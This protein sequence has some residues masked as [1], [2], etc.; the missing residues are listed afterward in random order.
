MDRVESWMQ[1]QASATGGSSPPALVTCIPGGGGGHGGVVRAAS[2]ND[3]AGVAAAT[4]NGCR[5]NLPV[6]GTQPLQPP[7]P[8]TPLNRNC[9]AG[10]SSYS[11]S[12]EFG[13]GAHTMQ[14]AAT[15][16]TWAGELGRG[17]G[18]G[19]G[20]AV[21]GGNSD[22][23]PEHVLQFHDG[24]ACAV[25]GVGGTQPRLLP[26]GVLDLAPPLWPLQLPLSLEPLSSVPRTQAA[27]PATV[28]GLSGG[29]AGRQGDMAVSGSGWGCLQER[30]RNG[31]HGVSS[32]PCRTKGR[33]LADG[34]A[35]PPNADCDAADTTGGEAFIPNPFIELEVGA[36]MGGN[37]EPEALLTPV[38]IPPSPPT[39]LLQ[40]QQQ[41]KQRRNVSRQVARGAGNDC[42][43]GGNHKRA[44]GSAALQALLSAGVPPQLL[45][46]LLAHTAGSGSSYEESC[47]RDARSGVVAD[48]PPPSTP[49]HAPAPQSHRNVQVTADLDDSRTA[50]P[51]SLDV[52]A[53]EGRWHQPHQ[54]LLPL[55]ARQTQLQKA[56]LPTSSPHPAAHRPP[57]NNPHCPYHVSNHLQLQQLQVRQQLLPY[58][59]Q[60]PPPGHA[61]AGV[62]ASPLN[63]P[64]AP[65][66]ASAAAAA[67]A[68]DPAALDPPPRTWKDAAVASILRH[69]ARPPQ[70]P[71]A[72]HRPLQPAPT[73][74]QT[75]KSHAA[76]VNAAASNSMIS[77]G[78]CGAFLSPGSVGGRAE[79]EGYP[80]TTS[81]VRQEHSLISASTCRDSTLPPRPGPAVAE[82]CLE[83]R[84]VRPPEERPLI[85]P[86]FRQTQP[87][88]TDHG[89][90][91][92]LTV[93]TQPEPAD[94]SAA[95]KEDEAA[96]RAPQPVAASPGGEEGSSNRLF[97]VGG[98]LHGLGGALLDFLHAPP[99]TASSIRSLLLS[100]RQQ[101]Q[102]C[103]AA[104]VAAVAPAKSGGGGSGSCLDSAGG[105][106]AP[107]GFTAA[108]ETHVTPAVGGA[109]FTL[110]ADSADDAMAVVRPGAAPAGDCRRS[111]AA[112]KLWA[113]GTQPDVW[114]GAFDFG[115]NG[116]SVG[117]GWS[118]GTVQRSLT[119]PSPS[120]PP[121]DPCD[122]GGR[123]GA[124]QRSLTVPLPSSPPMA[125]LQP[126][127]GPYKRPREDSS[128][129]SGGGAPDVTAPDVAAPTSHDA[130]AAL[131]AAITDLEVPGS[132]AVPMCI[133]DPTDGVRSTTTLVA[134]QE[135][136]RG[137]GAGGSGNGSEGLPSAATH[138]D[139]DGGG[140]G[141]RGGGG[142]GGAGSGWR[143]GEGSAAAMRTHPDKKTRLLYGVYGIG[144]GGGGG[145]GEAPA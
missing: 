67:A 58:T 128:G 101:Q 15:G 97:W 71:F 127:P 94:P 13:H 11:C 42:R 55:P 29:D 47:S 30:T 92:A 110:V 28:A 23:T 54:A 68:P 131:V 25:V 35:A 73:Q 120:S 59:D 52:A 51:A 117:T 38:P 137:S 135:L 77:H 109:N 103:A 142:G 115:G 108:A 40:Q 83:G 39:I 41:Q 100:Q 96:E 138:L 9:S 8:S 102:N 123:G 95:A 122:I 129:S 44:I 7:P 133:D 112:S 46:A 107:R 141:G 5:N 88:P 136:G 70:A 143:R 31:S 104:A 114:L 53:G 32:Y 72:V 82:E 21:H 64:P 14:T 57:H 60:A 12:Y 20:F 124:V 27:T 22:I 144:G 34:A 33:G 63:P 45:R 74:L 26:G 19:S 139:V 62:A 81:S 105:T 87:A 113:M 132:G 76:A 80:P 24:D 78:D 121:M 98:Q 50:A 75:S 49:E 61:S 43:G 36:G 69:L 85:A 116:V 134:E 10:S 2:K 130:S 145:C 66:P 118:G 4:G 84:H 16:C 86:P 90:G 17:S 3:Q 6:P 140:C 106:S 1:W 48:I 65:A 37:A 119:A 89:F 79:Q 56:Q 126:F 111:D 91:A 93:V 125:K 99:V 18:D